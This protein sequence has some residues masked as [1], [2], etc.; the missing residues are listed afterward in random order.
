MTKIILAA[1]AVLAMG[2]ATTAAQAA[3]K[4]WSGTVNQ[5]VSAGSKAHLHANNIRLCNNRC[6]IVG[7]YAGNIVGIGNQNLGPTYAGKSYGHS[8]GHSK[9]HKSWGMP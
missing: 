6:T 4:S 7:D 5:N 2:M 9:G 3:P 1:A 8:K